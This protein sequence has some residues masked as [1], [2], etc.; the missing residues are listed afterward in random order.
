MPTDTAVEAPT[1]RARQIWEWRGQ[2]QPAQQIRIEFVGEETVAA[3]MLPIQ[4]PRRDIRRITL[5]KLHA[6]YRLILEADRRA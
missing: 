3:M 4:W 2:E 5:R 1:V 6:E